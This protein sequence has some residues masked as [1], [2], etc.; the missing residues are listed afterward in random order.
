MWNTNTLTSKY[1]YAITNNNNE[2][3]RKA[4]G[5]NSYNC[6]QNKISDLAYKLKSH[7]TIHELSKH[8]YPEADD[9][10]MSAC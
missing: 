10:K 2:H 1:I 7:S 9:A 5:E 4:E 3:Q 6:K 8:K